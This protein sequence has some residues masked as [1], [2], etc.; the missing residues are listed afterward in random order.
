MTLNF[1]VEIKKEKKRKEKRKKTWGY[2]CKKFT[3]IHMY[4]NAVHDRVWWIME[5][6]K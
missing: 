5:T 4:T 1:E 3:C 6:P 2:A